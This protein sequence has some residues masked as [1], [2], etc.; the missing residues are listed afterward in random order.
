MREATRQKAV[1]LVGEGKV[2]ITFQTADVTSGEVIGEHGVYRVEINPA[3]QWCSC[4]HGKHRSPMAECSH[5]LAVK[6]E[7][8]RIGQ[9]GGVESG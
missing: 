8:E 1:T 4:E 7:R 5:V 6:V 3:G 9:G 2:K